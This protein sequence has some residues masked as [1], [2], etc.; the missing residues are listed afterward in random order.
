MSFL[1]NSFPL[2]ECSLTAV[3]QRREGKKKI[4]SQICR[5]S[6]D[7][8]R[9]FWILTSTSRSRSSPLLVSLIPNHNEQQ[10]LKRLTRGAFN[11]STFFSPLPLIF[12]ET[13]TRAPKQRFIISTKGRNARGGNAR[14]GNARDKLFRETFPL[15]ITRRY[16]TWYGHGSTQVRRRYRYVNFPRAHFRHEARL[17]EYQPRR[18]FLKAVFSDD[19]RWCCSQREAGQRG[20]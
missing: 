19:S 16:C 18:V 12:R 6:I 2:E 1:R 14:G 13:E 20:E 9:K 8:E 5:Q 15:V 3:G 11:V 17:I 7:Y 10:T 4:C